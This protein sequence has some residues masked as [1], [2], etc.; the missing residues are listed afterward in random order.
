MN[1]VNPSVVME[2]ETRTMTVRDNLS[3]GCLVPVWLF[4]VGSFVL[5]CL[6]G[7]SIDWSAVC[8][9]FDSYGRCQGKQG[10]GDRV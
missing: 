3:F 8:W 5:V 9:S 2:H 10:Q 7:L 4:G 1:L 6:S